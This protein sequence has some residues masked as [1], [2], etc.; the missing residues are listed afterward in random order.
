[1]K[2]TEAINILADFKGDG[3]SVATMQATAAWYNSGGGEK[4]HID[5]TGCMGGAA[6][7][8]LGLALAQPDKKV[9]VLDGDGSL[10]MQLGGIASIAGTGAENFYHIVLANRVYE[11]SGHQAIPAAK[12][13]DFAALAKAAGY[14][15]AENIGDI[16][17]LRE[18]LPGILDRR[19]PVLIA[20]EVEPEYE[21]ETVQGRRNRPGEQVEQ[22]RQQLVG[23]G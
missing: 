20:L 7:L 18:R 15:Y 17:V 2:R 4:H 11:T 16:G 8:G 19:G 12:T 5:C 13:V 9:F 22:M 6:S 1:M 21:R 23:Q 10:L 3:L 14:A